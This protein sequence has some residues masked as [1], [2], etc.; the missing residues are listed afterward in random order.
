MMVI[1]KWLNMSDV[2][3]RF[4][5][6]ASGFPRRV[7]PQVYFV[8]FNSPRS[9]GANSWLI[10]SHD[11]NWLIDSPRFVPE[12]V[13]RFKQ[14]GGLK[15]IF[16]THCDDVGDAALYAQ[17]FGAQRIIHERDAQAQPDA[18]IIISGDE[19]Q[20]FDKHFLVVPTPGHTRG[21]MVLLWNNEALFTGDH[22]ALER[23]SGRLYAFRDY[24]WYSWQEQT[25]SMA[26][27]LNYSF[28]WIFTGHG[29]WG[30]LP[31]GK[32]HSELEHLVK[33]MKSAA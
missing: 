2:K 30:H 23:H 15:Y 6:H 3:T 14:L 10:T 1:T 17:E 18:E 20:T 22:L 5:D 32:M 31:P 21:H 26:R 11:G 28:E 25:K 8:G 27:L 13:A 4:I 29:Q 16:L 19:P 24:C 9:Y 33:E 12:L 7:L